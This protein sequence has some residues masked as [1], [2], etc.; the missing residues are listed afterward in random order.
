MEA[1]T[2]KADRLRW[3]QYLSVG[4]IFPGIPTGM[5]NWSRMGYLYTVVLMAFRVKFYG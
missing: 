1:K 5:T 3:Q 2:E 4:P